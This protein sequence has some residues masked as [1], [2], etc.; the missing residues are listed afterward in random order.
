MSILDDKVCRNCK[1]NIATKDRWGNEYNHCDV[2]GLHIGYGDIVSHWCEHWS[3]DKT[4]E[5]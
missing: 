3:E 2:N 1:H 5:E 4:K